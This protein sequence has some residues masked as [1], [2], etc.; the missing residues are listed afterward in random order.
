MLGQAKEVLCPCNLIQRLAMFNQFIGWRFP[1]LQRSMEQPFDILYYSF[2]LRA[3]LKSM[4]LEPP[5]RAGRLES[6][7]KRW[8]E[9]IYDDQ[10]LRP[11]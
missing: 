11:H 10:I 4:T 6:V 1:G 2:N 9:I 7:C 3:F 5:K 8:A